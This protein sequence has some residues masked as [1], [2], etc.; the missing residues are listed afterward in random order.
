MLIGDI[1]IFSMIK[2]RMHWLTERQSVLA[3]NVANADTPR[4][5]ARDLKEVPF[6]KMVEEARGG[7]GAGR[8]SAYI[9]NAAHIPTTPSMGLHRADVVRQ[10][11][12]ETTPTGNSM[13]LEEQMIKVADTQLDYETMT[14]LY[15]RSLGLLKLALGR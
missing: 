15:S 8:V 1:P 14:G 9:T 11:D 5:T 13:V 4:Y 10:P 7:P 6:D 3:E 12:S 2:Q